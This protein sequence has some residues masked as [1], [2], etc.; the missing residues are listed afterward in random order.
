MLSRHDRAIMQDLAR[1][2]L[3]VCRSE[4]NVAKR[5]LW[6]RHNS[7]HPTRPLFQAMTRQHFIE[8]TDASRTGCEDPFLQLFERELKRRL[9]HVACDDDTVFEPWLVHH[10]THVPSS[11]GAGPWGVPFV[12]EQVPGGT[13]GHIKP[14]ILEP[15]D[16]CRL[17]RPSHHIDE[18]VT[19]E[20]R[21]KLLDAVGDI[22][23][24][25]IDRGPMLRSFP[26]DIATDVGFLRGHEQMMWDMVDRPDW[27]HQLLAFLRDGVQASHDACAAAGDWSRT[28][29]DNQS[30]PYAEELPLPSP[31]PDPVERR[32]LWWFMAA[33]EYASISPIRNAEGEITAVMEMSVDITQMKRLEEE[34][35]KSE[36]KYRVIFNN[37]P[38]PVFVLDRKSLS[39]LDCNDSVPPVYGFQKTDLVN[40]SFLNLFDEGEH[41]HYAL[42]IRTS[43]MLNQARQIT[44]DG[45]T[46]F[47]NIRISPS[48]YMG[49][50]SLLITT[51]DITKRMMAEQQLIQASKMA[52]LGEMAT[53]VAHELNQPLSV[54]KTA[55]SFISRKLKKNET[56]DREILNTLSEE[57]ESH[58]DR[59]SKITNHMRL[60][61][62]KSA[63]SKE[64]V[65]I[66]DILKKA[67]DIFS[68]Q[69]KLR[70]IT[71]K[72]ELDEKLPQILADPVRLEQVFINL[73]IN[74]R[75]AIVLRTETQEEAIPRQ[76][77]IT[78]SSSEEMVTA[79]I[80]DTGTGIPA[81]FMDKIFEP[82]FTTK[83]VGE[84]TGLGLSISYGIIRESGGDISVKNNPDPP[85]GATFII[86]F[87]M[88]KG[89]RK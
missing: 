52:T 54:I 37:I 79:S 16:L 87:H 39:I 72:W 14:T 7:L 47:V 22:L 81:E 9:Y 25:V 70:E 12:H 29:G 24:V 30:M 65:S 10:A 50:E 60:F 80:S 43:D 32:T 55:S 4:R 35:R 78:T 8:D 27:Y 63:F 45:R 31:S 62:R 49:R 42:E 23:P 48:E 21:D 82:F 20:G 1:R 66:N 85:G 73:L 83:K 44:R 11:P 6:I 59:A 77:T 74:A 71:V 2:Y 67:F 56:I 34:I 13:G 64:P 40:K 17:V 38:N 84:G 57:I 26:G 86:R 28:C 88:D 75:D 53:G 76:I 68:Q 18:V 58:V 5:Q 41:Q 33:Q 46:I 51:S 61:G 69:L 15:E 89:G 36:E 3:E 19:A